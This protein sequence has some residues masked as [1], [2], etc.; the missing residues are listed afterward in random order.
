MVSLVIDYYFVVNC[1]P[2]LYLTEIRSRKCRLFARKRISKGCQIQTRMAQKRPQNVIFE[3]F[4][5]FL[6]GF[7]LF[8]KILISTF[9]SALKHAQ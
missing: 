7:G 6:K 3:P 1:T 8:L 4:E 2:I 5:P 9:E